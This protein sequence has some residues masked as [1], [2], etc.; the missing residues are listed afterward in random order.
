MHITGVIL[1]PMIADGC[2]SSMFICLLTN[3]IAGSLKT[4]SSPRIVDCCVWLLKINQRQLLTFLLYGWR[5]IDGKWRRHTT[6]AYDHRREPIVTIVL[7]FALS[8]SRSY[9]RHVLQL[10]AANCVMQLLLAIFRVN[11]L[12]RT[13]TW[14]WGVSLEDPPFEHRINDRQ[15]QRVNK[16]RWIVSVETLARLCLPGMVRQT[17]VLYER[18]RLRIT[19]SCRRT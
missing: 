8:R 2:T 4:S 15:Y 5:S 18:R 3:W 14:S 13:S 7:A 11:V 10:R 17:N 16:T 6:R 12:F 1:A 19:G 9:S